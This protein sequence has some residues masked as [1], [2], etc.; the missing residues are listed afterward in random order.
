MSAVGR[1][2]SPRGLLEAGGV[3]LDERPIDGAELRQRMQRIHLRPPDA[4]SYE[5]ADMFASTSMGIVVVGAAAHVALAG[6]AV[7]VLVVCLALGVVVV[8]PALRE[9]QSARSP[10][11]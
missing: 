11:A 10:R 5:Y 9:R 7:A 2:P 3:R 8:W 1:S 6:L 4:P